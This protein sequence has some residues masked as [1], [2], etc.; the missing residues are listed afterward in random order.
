MINTIVAT[1]QEAQ[2]AF[3]DSVCIEAT[4]GGIGWL[5]DGTTLSAP[6]VEPVPV[7]IPQE[8]SIR[9][10][11]QVLEAAGL[12]DDV[13]AAIAQAPRYVQIDW[14]RATSVER[15]WPTLLAMQGTLGLTDE[16][17]DQMFFAASQL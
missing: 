7:T 12:L 9:Q 15:N 4:E 5:W 13:E 16:Q 8:I 1:P 14:Q 3:H 17:L 11:C 6:P 10:A 2:A